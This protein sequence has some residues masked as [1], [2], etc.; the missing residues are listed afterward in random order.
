MVETIL[1]QLNTRELAVIVWLAIAL[2]SMLFSKVIRK[3]I[4]GVLKSFFHWKIYTPIIGLIVYVTWLIFLLKH[5]SF[6]DISLLK[7]S[8]F[9]ILWAFSLLLSISGRNENIHFIK[10]IMVNFFKWILIIEFISNIYTF[11]FWW[12]LILV[13]IIIIIQ[14]ISTFASMEK[15]YV[16]VKIAF[17]YI[18]MWVIGIYWIHIIYSLISEPNILVNIHNL[19]SFLL[20]IVLTLLSIPYLYIF[21]LIVNYESLFARMHNCFRD[22]KYLSKL[23]KRKIFCL[24]KFNLKRLN[25]ISTSNLWFK[26]DMKDKKDITYLMSELKKHLSVE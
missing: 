21:T 13:P 4:W 14:L 3:S 22:D 10:D 19:Y 1:L 16:K 8:I 11:N 15:K 7:D 2:I 20:P 5:V 9:W 6:W 18:F 12:E 17:D 26:Y 25:N 24:C 23:L